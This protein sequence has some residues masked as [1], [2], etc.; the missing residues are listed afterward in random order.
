MNLRPDLHPN[1]QRSVV[2]RQWFYMPLM[3][4]EDVRD[5]D[6]FDDRVKEMSTTVAESG[7][8]TAVKYL[9]HM[10][11]FE[12]SHR[13]IVETFG[14]YAYRNKALGRENTKEEDEYMSGGGENFGVAG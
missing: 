1:I 7:D 12:K 3:H 6:L 2:Y 8:E 13:K 14:R 10:V 5:H 9:Q 4:S 11:G